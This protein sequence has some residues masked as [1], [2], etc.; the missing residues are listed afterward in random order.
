M[1]NCFLKQIVIFTCKVWG[2]T[3]NGM[4]IQTWLQLCDHVAMGVAQ[5]EWASSRCAGW[6]LPPVKCCAKCSSRG[7]LHANLGDAQRVLWPSQRPCQPS[8]TSVNTI[9]MVFTSIS[10][11]WVLKYSFLLKY[12]PQNYCTLNHKDGLPGLILTRN[13][14]LHWICFSKRKI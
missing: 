2:E 7:L 4:L 10:Y 11:S 14:P 9:S 8:L 13:K 5:I 3:R 1:L 12:L 6:G